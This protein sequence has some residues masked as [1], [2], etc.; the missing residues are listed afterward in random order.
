MF[1]GVM[2]LL[3]PRMCHKHSEYRL[4]SKKAITLLKEYNEKEIFL[5]GIISD[6][7]LKSTTVKYNRTP[8]INGRTKYNYPKLFA[9]AWR[10]IT[11]YSIFPLR[12]I[13]IL[14]GI[15]ILAALCAFLVMLIYYAKTSDINN[16]LILLSSICL[17]SGFIIFSLGLLGE[18]V[19]KILYEV[20]ERPVFQID[21]KKNC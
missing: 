12:L 5:R 18:Y 13:T 14:G 2:K 16:L 19:A 8:R 20:K 21:S 6:I 15:F 4:L 7:G 11:N 1:Y 17:F 10:G 9:L 3:C